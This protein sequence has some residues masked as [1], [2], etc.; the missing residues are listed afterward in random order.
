MTGQSFSLIS[1]STQDTPNLTIRGTVDRQRN[2]FSIHYMLTGDLAE[3]LLP[4][5]VTDPAR[6]DELWRMTCFEFFIAVKDSPQYW[7][8]NMS[9]SGDWNVYVMDAY[10]QVN[11]RE[12]TRVQRLQFKVQKDTEYFSM[13]AALDLNAINI[14]ENSIEAAISTVICS[15]N[16][17]ESYW[18]LV[19][20]HARPDFHLRGSFALEFPPGK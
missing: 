4:D 18:A 5:S 10:R 3:A 16:G 1:F 17:R 20:P 8:F 9:P 19:H 6:K 13:E 11:M 15:N 7:E 12:E 14:G 2:L